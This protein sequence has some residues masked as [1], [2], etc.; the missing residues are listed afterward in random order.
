MTSHR[1]IMVRAAEAIMDSDTVLKYCVEHFGRGL[2]INVGAYAQGIPTA[3]D[4]PFLWLLPDDSDNEA[5][6]DDST[7]SVRFVL[8]G[9]V[10]GPDGEQYIGD[11]VK[12]RDDKHN[13][14]TVNGGNAIVESLRDIIMCVIRNAKCGARIVKMRRSENDMAHF[15]LEWAEFFVDFV[16]DVSMSSSIS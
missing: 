9:C 16:E 15:P 11:M 10:K 8:G 6:N 5:V 2:D 4:S 13:G 7:F 14:L 12:A 3:D 1:T